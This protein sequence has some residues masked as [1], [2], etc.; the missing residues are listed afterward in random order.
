M[1][2]FFTHIL[3]AF[4]IYAPLQLA[5]QRIGIHT[6]TPEATLDVRTPFG[7]NLTGYDHVLNVEYE[8]GNNAHVTALRAVSNPTPGYGIGAY[9]AGGSLGARVVGY[10]YGLN[11]QCI[12]LVGAN[13]AGKGITVQYYGESNQTN[14]GIHSMM[15][16]DNAYKNC[17]IFG[18]ATEPAETNIGL[19]GRAK[20]AAVNWAGY[21]ADGNV[22]IQNKLG[23]GYEEPLFTIDARDNQAVIKMVTETSSNGSVIELRN[24]AGT[25][26][27]LGAINFGDASSTSGQI[28]YTGTDNMTFRV[29]SLGRMRL[30]ATGNL[31]IGRLPLTNKLE[32]EGNASKSTAGDWVANS[33]ERLKKN[34]H[35]L[36]ANQMLEKLLSMKGITY[37]WNDDKTGTVRPEGTQ[38]GFTAQNIKTVF[39]E[40]VE[41]DALGYLQT[42]Y[43]TYDAMMVEA[44]RAMHEKSLEQELYVHQLQNQ[45]TEQAKVI[46]GLSE[47]VTDLKSKWDMK[48]EIIIE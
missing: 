41:E 26:T 38:Y 37:E 3:I 29:N 27:Y 21:F 5:A 36:D 12:P 7:L 33:D 44:I 13:Y 42:A 8:G 6:E 20:D 25:Q 40:L 31:G 17:A 16:S 18:D 34:I 15:F 48:K 45:L 43:G 10:S 22:Y 1:K 46:A 14:Y 32:V 39:P 19:Y 2:S 24:S 11:V 30:S 28:A 9:M 4:F 35:A 23:I 47:L